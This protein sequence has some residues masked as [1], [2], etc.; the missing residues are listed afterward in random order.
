MYNERY[1]KCN[2]NI[3]ARSFFFIEQQVTL[4]LRIGLFCKKL[5]VSID[6]SELS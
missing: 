1:D 5:N 3:S 2:K 4:S 6:F